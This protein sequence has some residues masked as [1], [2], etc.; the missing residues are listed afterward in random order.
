[1]K[2]RNNVQVVSM[3][4]EAGASVN[5]IDTDGCTALHLA[6]QD[7]HRSI[8]R[9]LLRYG[10]IADACERQGKT[11]HELAQEHDHPEVV[12]VLEAWHAQVRTTA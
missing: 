10:A 2:L 6:A 3:L 1:M 9:T 5:A 4:L 8:V 7:G 12:A 11:A